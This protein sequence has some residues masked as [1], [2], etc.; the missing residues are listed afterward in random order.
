MGTTDHPAPADMLRLVERQAVIDVCTRMAWHADR[1]DWEALKDVFADEVRLDYTSLNGG[2]PALLAPREIADAWSRV[3]GGFD[4]TQHLIANH[5]VTLAEDTAVCTAAF[6]ATHR[7]ADPFGAPLWTLGG[8]YRFDLVRSGEG[9]RIS[10]V[11][12][13]AVW[14]DGNRESTASAARAAG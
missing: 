7:L 8:T 14:G 6:Q 5:L 9:W 3:L 13:T 11:V 12:M 10:G 4:A 1:R 2:E